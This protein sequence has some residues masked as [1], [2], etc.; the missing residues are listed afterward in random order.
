MVMKIAK[1]VFKKFPQDK[2]GYL[3]GVE[4]IINVLHFLH[5]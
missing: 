5:I 2:W 4:L 1:N 3:S